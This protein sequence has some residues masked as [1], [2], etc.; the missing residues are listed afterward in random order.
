MFRRFLAIIKKE[1][2]QI[3]R[4]PPSL[5]ISFIMPVMMLLFFGYAVN[6][7]VD[8]IPLAVWDQDQSQ[9]SRELTENLVQTRYFDLAYRVDSGHEIKRFLTAGG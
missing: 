4:D 6:T 9:A 3:R 1:F 2:I 5:V 7:D 8:H